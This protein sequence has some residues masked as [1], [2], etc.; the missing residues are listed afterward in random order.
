[1]D[2]DLVVFGLIGT[3]VPDDGIVARPLHA[4]LSSEDVSVDDAHVHAVR[5]LTTRNALRLLLQSHGASRAGTAAAVDRIHDEVVKQSLA[6]CGSESPLREMLGVS[7]AFWRLRQRGIKVAI[8]TTLPRSIAETIASRLGWTTRSLVDALV[9]ADDVDRG[10][11][12]PDA[13]DVAMRVT[14]ARARSRVVT[15][16]SSP[17]ELQQGSAAGAAIVVAVAHDA[18]H[19][20]ELSR[21]PHSVQLPTSALLPE[22][23]QRIDTREA[24][25]LAW[26]R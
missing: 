8:V 7:Q 11:P 16:G 12:F 21:Y 13:V 22:L 2:M 1:M 9:T 5:G 25:P 14:G 19:A 6:R 17:A 18:K 15:V 10:A 23:L 20:A 26:A 24:S 4:A 3:T